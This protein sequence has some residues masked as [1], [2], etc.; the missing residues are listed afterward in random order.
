MQTDFSNGDTIRIGPR[1]IA[2]APTTLR[3]ISRSENQTG[4]AGGLLV[5]MFC[6]LIAI[7]SS[8][9]FNIGLHVT[10]TMR[11][12]SGESTFT[13]RSG[14]VLAGTTLKYPLITANNTFKIGDVTLMEIGWSRAVIDGWIHFYF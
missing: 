6:S 1:G 14:L 5:T 3:G 2:L 4:I 9:T 8:I 10:P 12:Y 7:I 11:V 13:D